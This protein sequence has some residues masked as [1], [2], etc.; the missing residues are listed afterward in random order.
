MVEPFNGLFPDALPKS[1]DWEWHDSSFLDEAVELLGESEVR[2]QLL[3]S[4]DSFI[5]R[6]RLQWEAHSKPEEKA[7]VSSYKE[8]MR[9][10]SL[11]DVLGEARKEKPSL[12]LFR[13]WGMHAADCELESV[14]ERLWETTKPAEMLC[15][16]RVFS[17]QAL[18]TFDS[19][20]MQLCQHSNQD[21]QQWAFNALEKNS[22]D[23]IRQF[24]LDRLYAGDRRAVGLF[25]RNHE[26]EDEETILDWIEL[27]DAEFA[28]HSILLDAIKVLE[29]NSQADATKLGV[30]A[31]ASTPC[32]TCRKFAAQCLH[33]QKVAPDWLTEECRFDSVDDI[34]TLA[35]DSNSSA[36]NETT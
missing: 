18:P 3:D 20:L 19:R 16:L 5:D 13:G 30:V 27:P 15:L 10:I 31:Y 1:R 7:T 2:R 23:A 25:I 24:A 17:N 11:C 12:G 32:G 21:V 4:D 6:F 26:M 36:D 35:A 34:R 9:A 29:E 8:R 33:K 14:L 22:N 28:R